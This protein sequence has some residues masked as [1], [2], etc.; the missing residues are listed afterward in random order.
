MNLD[1]NASGNAEEDPTTLDTLSILTFGN[2]NMFMPKR[3][4]ERKRRET[5][6]QLHRTW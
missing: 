6:V 2:L 1:G 5:S 4:Y 3:S